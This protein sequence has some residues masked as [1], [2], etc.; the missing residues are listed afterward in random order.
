MAHE[1]VMCGVTCLPPFL[2]PLPLG[3]P[4]LLLALL[5]YRASSDSG[6]FTRTAW[7]E[8]ITICYCKEGT[9]DERRAFLLRAFG[10]V[11]TCDACCLEGD[12]LAQSDARQ[13]RMREIDA[14]ITRV[15]ASCTASTEVGGE[16]GG[17]P[18]M[19][20]QLLNERLKLMEA[21]GVAETAWVTEAL[22]EAELAAELFE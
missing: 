20:L 1:I 10:F 8:E 4:W 19:L 12:A 13:V 21:E 7:G 22:E 6:T 15:S 11:C 14:E 18:A 5:K 17:A 3:P 2:L 9:R 16:A